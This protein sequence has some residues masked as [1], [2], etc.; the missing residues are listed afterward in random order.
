MGACLLV[1]RAAIAEV[2]PPDPSFFLFSEEVDWCYRFA[3]AGWKTR[4]TPEARCVHVG[5]ASHGG[6]MFQENLRG[7]LRFFLKHHGPKEAERVRTL[8]RASLTLRG[9][10]VQGPQGETY[11]DAA[12]WLGTGD[13]R[14]LIER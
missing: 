10:V 13:A 12:R 11:R 3:Q 7:Q 4:F 14:S 1:R 2:G 9:R 5:G 6:R 8:L